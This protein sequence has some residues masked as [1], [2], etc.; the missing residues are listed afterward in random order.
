MSTGAVLFDKTL[1]VEDVDGTTFS[2]V[3]NYS[4]FINFFGLTNRVSAALPLSTGNWEGLVTGEPVPREVSRT[5]VGD[6]VISSM[7]FVLGAPSM[8]PAEYRTYQRGTVVGLNLRLRVP[9]GQYDNEKL[10]NIGSN[11]WQAS[12]AIGVSQR[13]G[14]FT[15]EA[16]GAAW[17]FSDNKEFFP[18][19]TLSQD[20]LFALQLNASYNFK[21][22][23]WIAIGGRRTAAG[24]T[25]V[26]G[27]PDS[28]PNENSRV[29]LVLGAPLGRKWTVKFLATTAARSETG[30]DFDTLNGQ[31]FYAW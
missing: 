16:R 26:N 15:L 23:F 21:P 9:T 30:N 19:N 29:G 20:P 22:R 18:D 2:W 11:R 27:G 24:R 1:Q 14:R 10:I 13:L 5:G 31:L 7:L 25:S 4:R 3:P 28:N 12:P 8:T 6:A 17:F